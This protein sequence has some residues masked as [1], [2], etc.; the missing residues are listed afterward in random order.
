MKRQKYQLS[1]ENTDI[2]SNVSEK[3]IDFRLPNGGYATDLAA[4]IFTLKDA[5]SELANLNDFADNVLNYHQRKTKTWALET[6]G[7]CNRIVLKYAE[8]YP[9]L[10]Q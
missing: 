5:N 6:I 8:R 4:A 10:L 1:L 2:A 7:E 3:M 9:N